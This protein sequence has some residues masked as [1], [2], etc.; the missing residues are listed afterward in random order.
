[1]LVSLGGDMS[2]AGETP[3]GGWSVT[4]GDSSDLD[5]AIGAEPEQTIV[6]GSGGLATSSIR[7]RRWRRGGSELHHLIDPR[8]G[9]PS[10]GT[11]RT[12]SVAASTCTLANAASTAAI[13]LG[14]DA[15]SWL[16]E[17]ALPA[18]L[19]TRSGSVRHVAGWPSDGERT[20]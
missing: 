1:V 17:R 6:I 4:V 7:A 11:L 18:R 19:V 16:S 14:A 8:I 12:V 10:E 13:I 5:A 9:Q 20:P 3:P 15:A 2:L